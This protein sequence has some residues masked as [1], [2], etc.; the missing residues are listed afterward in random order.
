M[1]RRTPNSGG[2]LV[3]VLAVIMVAG[4]VTAGWMMTMTAEIEYVALASESAKR[5][6][7]VN[8]ATAL[9]RQHVLSNVLT[10]TGSTGATADIGDG[11]GAV[12]IPDS[13]GTPLTTFD[14]PPWYNHF[15]PGNG[16]GYALNPYGGAVAMTAN[17]ESFS[18][19]FLVKSRSSVLSGTPVAL[20]APSASVTG[21]MTV[22]GQTLL[23]L[24]TGT[25]SLTSATFATPAT[26]NANILASNF[27]F[28]PLTGSESGNAPAFNGAL[29][30]V[31]NTS[32][33]NS[34][35]VM[36][37]TSAINGRQTVNG[38]VESDPSS[39]TNGVISDG[40][41]T[42]T[43]DLRNEDLGNVVIEGG[44]D[45]LILKGQTSE[46]DRMA[47][48]NA[49]AALIIVY[50][51]DPVTHLTKNLTSVEF[52]NSNYRKVVLAIKTPSG[53]GTTFTM[54][55]ADT[56]VWRTV[57]TLENTPVTFQ[58]NGMSRTLTGGV[59]TDQPVVIQGGSLSV[60]PETDPKLLDRLT[61]RDGW[62][63]VFAP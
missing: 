13:T 25:Y 27:P 2:V 52:Q 3:V 47:A 31:A 21:T 54:Q 22:D 6:I 15:N 8:N 4:A 19:L 36:S 48:G 44:T 28:V 1:K 60:D 29:N 40:E 33:I 23:W 34:L 63:E 32:G 45:H 12:T 18:R 5:R 9:V 58:L 17:G 7:A 14:P 55:P 51:Y 37:I 49:A 39:G 62:V 35:A 30:V 10:K 56:D 41:G 26:P 57:F 11:W 38:E 46:A 61:A 24:P 43:I 59:Q 53:V 16:G 20:H 42:V 50:Q